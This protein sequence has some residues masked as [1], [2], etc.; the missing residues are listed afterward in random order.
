[1]GLRCVHGIRIGEQEAIEREIQKDCWWDTWGMTTD[2]RSRY[3]GQG[4]AF[5]LFP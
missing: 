5:A 3:H 4:L 1:M 2:V